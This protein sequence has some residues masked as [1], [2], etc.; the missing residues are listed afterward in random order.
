[1]SDQDHKKSRR[2]FVAASAAAAGAIALAKDAHAQADEPTLKSRF[3]FTLEAVLE[4]VQDIGERQIYIVKSG[5]ITGPRINGIVLPGGGDWAQRNSDGK[6][7][8]DVRATIKTDDDQLIYTWYRG[9]VAQKDTGL[10]FR[11]TPYFETASEKYAWLNT[12]VAVG[13][14]KQVPGKVAYDVFEIL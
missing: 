9:I 14:H 8:L 11:T 3:L 2:E 1:M 13:V 7:M 12:V 5:E 10:Y 6:T 4:P